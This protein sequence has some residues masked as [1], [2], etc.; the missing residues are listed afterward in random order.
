MGESQRIGKHLPLGQEKKVRARIKPAFGPDAQ[1]HGLRVGLK[2]LIPS[3]LLVEVE[4]LR[5]E[6]VSSLDLLSRLVSHGCRG[7]GSSWARQRL[8]KVGG[9]SPILISLGRQ[10]GNLE[11]MKMQSVHTVL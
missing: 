7:R 5:E 1:L 9:S 6:E 11:E 10:T 8:L 3:P 2:G 4:S